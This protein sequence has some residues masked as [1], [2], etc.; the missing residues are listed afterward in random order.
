MWGFKQVLPT[1]ILGMLTAIGCNIGTALAQDGCAGA[2]AVITEQSDMKAIRCSL[3]RS[4]SAATA[5]GILITDE[6]P[7]V[8]GAK[9]MINFKFGS[10]ELTDKAKSLL[11]RIAKVIENDEKLKKSAFFIDGH[12]DAVGS[13]KSNQKLGFARAQSA[14]VYLASTISIDLNAKIRSYGEAKLLKP[15]NPKSKFNRR[16]EIT[17]VATE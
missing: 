9:F 6:S 5:R 2:P 4:L 3:T 17:P 14:T 15:D 11:D 7:Q 8:E 12:T 16:V 1:A 13:A 10:A